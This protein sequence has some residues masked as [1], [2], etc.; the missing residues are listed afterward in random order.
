MEQNKGNPRKFWRSINN[1]SGLGKNK[2][3]KGIQKIV[4]DTGEEIENLD[5]AEFMNTYYTE[6]GPKL[7]T[8]FD[9]DWE[10]SQNLKEHTSTFEFEFIPESLVKKLVSDIKISKSSAVDNLSSRILK[11]AFQVIIFELTLI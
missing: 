6:A 4:N 10:A 5:A 2:N 9:T 3:K 8:K 11:D 1:I 7:A